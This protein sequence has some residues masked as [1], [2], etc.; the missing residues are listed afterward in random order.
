MTNQ[1]ITITAGTS[2]VYG[3][4]APGEDLPFYV[5]HGSMDAARPFR[6]GRWR[7]KTWRDYVRA[8]G[9]TY[10][11][12]ILAAFETKLEAQEHERKLISKYRPVINV[13]TG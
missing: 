8:I 1:C 9:G 3:H 2:V 6:G 5:G 11:V 12:R 13:N 7:T 4:F 10:E